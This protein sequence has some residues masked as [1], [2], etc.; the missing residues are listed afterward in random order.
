MKG[1]Y[2]DTSEIYES[3][4]CTL[5]VLNLSPLDQTANVNWMFLLFPVCPW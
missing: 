5:Q 3:C 2:T 1:T 4:L